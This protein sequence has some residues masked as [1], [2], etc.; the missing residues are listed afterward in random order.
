MITVSG[1]TIQLLDDSNLQAVAAARQDKMPAAA[2]SASE[3]PSAMDGWI[4]G[5]WVSQAHPSRRYV[6]DAAVHNNECFCRTLSS[7][8]ANRGGETCFT[9]LAVLDGLVCVYC[10]RRVT[11]L[12]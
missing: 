5:T 4:G 9:V 7:T 12:V 2:R 10:R 6:S 1:T 8:K 3:R 11:C